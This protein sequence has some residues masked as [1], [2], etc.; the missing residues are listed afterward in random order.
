MDEQPMEP[1]IESIGVAD[2]ANVQPGGQER[3]LD[4]IGRPVVAAQDQPRCS[5]QLIER[6]R[7]ERREGVVIAVPGAKDEVSLHRTP[8]SWRPS[9][10]AYPS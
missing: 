3:L 4:G 5:M 6:I 2:R 1:G 9:G 8:G 10:R 7:G